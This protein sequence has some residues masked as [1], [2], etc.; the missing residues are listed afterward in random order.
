ML[1]RFTQALAGLVMLAAVGAAQERPCSSIA[2]KAER[3]ADSFFDIF[4][5]VV[6]TPP[7]TPSWLM[8]GL[9]AGETKWELPGHTAIL[10]IEN[11]VATPF[12]GRSDDRGSVGRRFLLPSDL[13][14]MGFHVQ[15]VNVSVTP[16]KDGRPDVD[17]CLSN[18]T[19]LLD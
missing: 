8:V 5:E 12:L 16:S 4:I 18:A 11:I 17:T 2:I 9:D 10:G 13:A 3:R 6:E 1:K 7:S 15:S 14:L 19:P